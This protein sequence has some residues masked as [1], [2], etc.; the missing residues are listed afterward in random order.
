MPSR[1]F[2]FLPIALRENKFLLCLCDWKNLAT[3]STHSHSHAHAQKQRRTCVFSLDVVAQTHPTQRRKEVAET[4][5]KGAF[6]RRPSPNSFTSLFLCR[7]C[8]AYAIPSNGGFRLLHFAVQ[9]LTKRAERERKREMEGVGGRL[10]EVR[11]FPRA[12]SR[13]KTGW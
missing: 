5:V 3:H 1:S 9:A 6:C 11:F 10:V 7:M 13:K 4:D 2:A 12:H 8:A